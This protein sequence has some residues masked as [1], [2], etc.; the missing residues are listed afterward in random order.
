MV[1]LGAVACALILLRGKVEKSTNCCGRLFVGRCGWVYYCRGWWVWVGGFYLGRTPG[2]RAGGPAATIVRA[3]GLHLERA[4]KGCVWR[5]MRAW[6]GR[7]GRGTGGTMLTTERSTLWTH[8]LQGR[9]GSVC[10]SLLYCGRHITHFPFVFC[11]G[12]RPFVK[13]AET[14]AVALTGVFLVKVALY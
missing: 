4:S 10:T 1:L 5:T 13:N 6:G 9:C 8:T 14:N 12:K 2:R 3:R 11:N 7:S